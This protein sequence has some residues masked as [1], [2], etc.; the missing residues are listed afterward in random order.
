MSYVMLMSEKGKQVGN[1]NEM[2]EG[3]TV[4]NKKDGVINMEYL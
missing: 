4:R 3:K 2:K 1:R